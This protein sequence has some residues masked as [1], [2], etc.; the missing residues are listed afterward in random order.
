MDYWL[1][2]ASGRTR[3]IV[4]TDGSIACDEF[5]G[6][7]D[8]N[9]TTA[10]P[11]NLAGVYAE[12]PHYLDLRWAKGPRATALVTR[13]LTEAERAQFMPGLRQRLTAW[14]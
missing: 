12:E 13:S 7:F 14:R 11:P 3:L 2:H 6:D 4:L 9:A 5:R 8:W 10:L 1:T